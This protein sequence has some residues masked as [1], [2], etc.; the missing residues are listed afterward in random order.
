[1]GIIY[2][3]FA[4]KAYIIIDIIAC[5]VTEILVQVAFLVFDNLNDIGPQDN[6][7]APKPVEIHLADFVVAEVDLFV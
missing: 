5:S 1:M 3:S 7:V 4:R 6:D 2:V